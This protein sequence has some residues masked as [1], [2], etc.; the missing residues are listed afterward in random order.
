MSLVYQP[1]QIQKYNPGIYICS[2]Y[3]E[4]FFQQINKD[5]YWCQV[6]LYPN[7]S[8]SC[9]H[10]YTLDAEVNFLLTLSNSLLCFI[11]CEV[12]ITYE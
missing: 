7:N 2:F 10:F 12:T 6:V 3:L 5:L 9:I 4:L 11:F 8:V 1:E